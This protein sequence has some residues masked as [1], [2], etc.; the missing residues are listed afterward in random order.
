[1]QWEELHGSCPGRGHIPLPTSSHWVATCGVFEK[2][3][4]G[5]GVPFSCTLAL[6]LMFQP[7]YAIKI[8]NICRAFMKFHYVPIVKRLPE[9]RRCPGQRQR[10]AL[11]AGECHNSTTPPSKQK[12][13]EHFVSSRSIDTAG[14]RNGRLTPSRPVGRYTHHMPSCSARPCWSLT[15][16]WAA[17]PT[18]PKN[19][20]SLHQSREVIRIFQSVGSN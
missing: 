14:R 12:H 20:L 7:L 5:M 11:L 9:G 13:T 19:S 4:R 18:P 16:L 3:G 6:L 8:Q 10:V 17:T 2:F 1:M 15:G